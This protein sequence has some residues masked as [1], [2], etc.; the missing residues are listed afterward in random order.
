MCGT[1]ITTHVYLII[2][3]LPPCRSAPARQACAAPRA[4][5]PPEG[6]ALLAP[7]LHRRR[8]RGRGRARAGGGSTPA[9]AGCPAA[10]PRTTCT[11][12]CAGQWPPPAPPLCPRTPA[13]ARS[14]PSRR[15]HRCRPRRSGPRLGPP[16]APEQKQK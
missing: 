16:P 5:A 9:P 12:P 6:C 13:L 1:C 15:R 8:R 10:T 11:P 7:T 3:P 2:A 14:A 4:G